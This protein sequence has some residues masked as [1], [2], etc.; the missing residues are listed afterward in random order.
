MNDLNGRIALVTGAASGIGRA[1]AL[2]LADAGVRV[3]VCD[4]NPEGLADVEAA[5]RQKNACFLARRVD[6]SKRDAVKALADAVHAEV[7]ALDILV[8]NAGVGLSG[9][10]LSTSLD[11]WEWVLGVNLWGVIHGCHFFAPEMAKR[12]SGHIANVASVFGYFAP[13]NVDGYATT[14]FGVVGLSES[15]RAELAPRGVGVST[16]CPGM[17]DTGII[18]GTRFRGEVDP[19]RAR[20]HIQSMYDKRGHA[21]EQVARAIVG[22]IRKDKPLVPVTPEAWFLYY[23]KRIA[24]TLGGPLARAVEARTRK[25]AGAT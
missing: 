24:P 20:N 9:G 4:V 15:M 6:V 7:P 12:G 13:P 11:D 17:I 14:K 19:E 2:A 16:I 21:P 25:R 8:N 10:I 3:A 5:L 22:A 1:T 18:R 23:A